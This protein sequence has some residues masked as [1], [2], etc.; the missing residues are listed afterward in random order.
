M[1][2]NYDIEIVVKNLEDWMRWSIDSK[3]HVD[4]EDALNEPLTYLTHLNRNSSAKDMIERFYSNRKLA[5]ALI[6]AM[7]L[8]LAS[9]MRILAPD[10]F[11]SE[12]QTLEWYESKGWQLWLF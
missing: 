10:L 2:E 9:R 12:M 4:F 11:E 5:R 3:K 1:P 8:N 6:P 7:K